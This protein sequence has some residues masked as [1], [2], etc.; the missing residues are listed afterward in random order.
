[1]K[2]FKQLINNSGN[3]IIIYKEEEDRMYFLIWEEANYPHYVKKSYFSK[4]EMLKYGISLKFIE[5]NFSNEIKRDF[6]SYI[7]EKL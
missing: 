7:M 1:M 6:I 2:L 5:T 4:K 3:Q